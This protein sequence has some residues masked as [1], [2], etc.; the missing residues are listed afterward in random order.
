MPASWRSSDLTILAV[1]GAVTIALTIA[2]FIIAPTETRPRENGSSYA[3]HGDGAM[4]AFLLL[5]QL[6][7]DVERSFEPL[8]AGRHAPDR[9]V[10][11]IADPAEAPSQQDLRALRAF[12]EGGGHLLAVGITAA[13][14]LPFN[15]A[16]RAKL[17]P[18]RTESAALVSPLSAGVPDVEMAPAVFSLSLESP[19][20][21]IYGT[22][23]QPAILSAAL[24]KGRATWWSD[25]APLVNR[26]ISRAGHTE[27]LINAVGAPG[28]RTILWDEFYH[29]HARSVWSYVT[30]TPLPLGILQLAVAGGVALFSVSRRRRPI[31][32]PVVEP[33]TSPLE[34]I[35]TMAGLYERARTANAAVDALRSHL[36]RRIG[37]I[38]GLPPSASD[39]QVAHAAADRF[40]LDRAELTALLEDAKRA[41]SDPSIQSD[42]ALRIVARLQTV[43]S[44][45]S[46]NASAAPA[47]RRADV[48]RAQPDHTR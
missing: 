19:Y 17:G 8:A 26:G 25:S 24:G 2:L 33:R 15:P 9:T 10:L 46:G 31:R 42:E 28:E 40:P 30:G 5:K 34:F 23:A 7:Y 4:A 16:G 18:E 45:L 1:V 6:G 13:R 41:A 44:T 14:F 12:V 11:V 29:G 35:D 36:R 32:A 39:E 3:A 48:R 47:A 43:A 27:L 37:L 22:E 20:V 21:P 38:A